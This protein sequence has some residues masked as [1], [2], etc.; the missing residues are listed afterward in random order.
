MR[1]VVIE[2][3]AISILRAICQDLPPDMREIPMVLLDG[4]PQRLGT[5]LILVFKVHFHAVNVSNVLKILLLVDIYKF[6]AGYFRGMAVQA[7]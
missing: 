1:C 6:N 3:D 5:V 4:L 2:P 7:V